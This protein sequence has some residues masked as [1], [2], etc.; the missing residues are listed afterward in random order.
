MKE[1]HLIARRITAHRDT[2]QFTLGRPNGG[3][4][5]IRGLE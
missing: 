5:M 3:F 1:F 4:E 2:L